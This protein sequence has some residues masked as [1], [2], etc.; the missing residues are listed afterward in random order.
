MCAMTF[1]A[2]TMHEGMPNVAQGNWWKGAER[3]YATENVLQGE[4]S[5]EAEL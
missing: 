5:V 3:T 2:L 4:T 1:F